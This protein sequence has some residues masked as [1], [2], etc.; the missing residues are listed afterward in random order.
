MKKHRTMICIGACAAAIG[1]VP[2]APAF[3]NSLLSGYGGPGQCNQAILGSALINGP[4]GNGGGSGGA[5]SGGSRSSGSAGGS[6][7]AEGAAN[8]A[9]GAGAG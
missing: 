5:G 8:A 7:A 1:S 9:S 4:G 2:A 6:T 3:A